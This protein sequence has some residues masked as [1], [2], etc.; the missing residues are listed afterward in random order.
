MLSYL[1]VFFLGYRGARWWWVPA[2]VL[3]VVTALD[4][5]TSYIDRFTPIPAWFDYVTDLSFALA[6]AFVAYGLG[7]C[8][9][10]MVAAAFDRDI[11]TWIKER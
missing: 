5:Y 10:L 1:L 6:G 8:V 2:F 3:P 9:A 7:R 11:P 4:A